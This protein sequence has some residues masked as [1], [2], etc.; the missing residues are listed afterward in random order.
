MDLDSILPQ[1]DIPR[2]GYPETCE[3]FW[4]IVD[5]FTKYRKCGGHP[6]YG[7]RDIVYRYNSRGY[8]CPEFDQ[9]ADIRMIS[10]GCSNTFGHGLPQSAIFH[11]LFAERLRR[12]SG[13]TVVNWNLGRGGASC[14]YVARMLHLAVSR[15]KPDIVLILFPQLSRREYVS[16]QGRLIH[17]TSNYFASDPVTREICGHL[18]ALSNA[19][20]DQ[21]NFYRNYKSIESLLAQHPWLYSFA[22]AADAAAVMRYVDQ[23]R[24][25]E[26]TQGIDRARDG[27]H[28]GP[29]TNQAICEGFW[30]R[31]VAIGGRDLFFSSKAVT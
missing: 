8:R 15:L 22:D 19:Y 6:L 26:V 21:L 20:D 18:S 4:S 16:A 1:S 2:S 28:P 25:V 24:F 31:F 5:T 3:E 10:I 23:A 11:E 29:Q 13:K 30:N 17:Y 12:E 14:D 7:E 27:A 9:D